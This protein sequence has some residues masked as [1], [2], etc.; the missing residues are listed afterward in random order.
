MR[1]AKEVI[2]LLDGLVASEEA[3]PRGRRERLVDANAVIHLIRNEDLIQSLDWG[4][5][6]VLAVDAIE[7]EC[8]DAQKRTGVY[9]R[10]QFAELIRAVVSAAPIGSL[11]RQ[12]LIC[13]RL[14]DACLKDG[15]RASTL[16][17]DMFL[18]TRSILE[19]EVYRDRVTSS[20]SRALIQRCQEAVLSGKSMS[21]HNV[22]RVLHLLVTPTARRE[23]TVDGGDRVAHVFEFIS[24][25]IFLR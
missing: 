20:L 21:L 18:L 5:A 9:P 19:V 17:E 25:V 8:R 22:Q 24:E 12:C 7:T 4:A 2:T 16:G 14:A 1:R 10:K 3:R 11:S 6:T 13:L 23:L 15:Y